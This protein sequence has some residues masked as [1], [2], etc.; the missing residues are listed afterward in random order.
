VD[1]T[2]VDLQRLGFIHKRNMHKFD[3]RCL[4]PVPDYDSEKSAR[5][6]TTCD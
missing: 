3:A 4:Q 2:A 1:E 6:V 5:C